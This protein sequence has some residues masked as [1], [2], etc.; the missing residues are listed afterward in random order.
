MGIGWLNSRNGSSGAVSTSNLSE[1]ALQVLKEETGT[2]LKKIDRYKITEEND[3]R[4]F[5]INA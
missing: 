5:R 3:R 1:N 4:D 2:L